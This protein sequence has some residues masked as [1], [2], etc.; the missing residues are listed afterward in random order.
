M[1]TTIKR[2]LA[3]TPE[4]LKQERKQAKVEAKQKQAASGVMRDAMGRILP[5]Y[6]GNP[7]GR[8]KTALSELCRAEITKHG[9]VS[10]LGSIAARTGQYA[11]KTKIP[12]TVSDQINAIRLLLTYGF[13]LPKSEIDNGNVEIKVTYDQRQVKILNVA[14]NQTDDPTDQ[15]LVDVTKQLEN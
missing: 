5:G 8:P 7:M 13:G 11:H 14:E 12:V 10:V 1:K 15:P 9:L 3:M 4:E 6:T 2:A